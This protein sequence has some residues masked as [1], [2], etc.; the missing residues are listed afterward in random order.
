MAAARP[1]GTVTFLCTAVAES[2]SARGGTN[3]TAGAV[4]RRDSL[5]REAI[6]QHGGYTFAAADNGVAAAFPTAVGAAEAAIELQQQVLTERGRLGV[7]GGVGLHTG[8]ASDG[9]SSYVGP[10]AD[11]AVRLTSIAY[12][13]QIVVSET[14][15]LLLRGRMTLRTLGE[16]RLRD[17]HR[18]MTVHQLIADGLP[19]EFRALRSTDPTTGNLPEQLTSLVGRDALLVEVADLVRTNRLVTLGGAGGVGKTRLALEVGA[20]MA[21]EFPDGVWVVELAAVS[22]AASVTAAIATA[23]GIL[24][25]GDGELIDA[26]ADVLS[27]RRALVVIDNCEHLLSAVSAAISAILARSGPAR[28]PQPLGST[29]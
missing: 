19:S 7:E 20:G 3:A 14:T 22:D 6:A 15:E 12:G 23:L 24:P 27:N 18:R 26:V 16:H 1:A 11:R 9:T 2:S 28:G 17:L 5:V 21:G 29:L 4:E 10:E 25:R 8:E 13:G